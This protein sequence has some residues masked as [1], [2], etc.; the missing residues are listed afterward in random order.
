MNKGYTLI[1]TLISLLIVS[2][3]TLLLSSLLSIILKYE[4]VLHTGDDEKSIQQMRILYA[5]SKEHE[6]NGDML[7]FTY[8]YQ[9][10]NYTFHNH[11]LILEDGYQLFLSDLDTA[12]F[13]NEKNCF[14]IHYKRKD[15]VRK[16][17]IG[18]E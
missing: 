4:Y 14:Y 3:C 1:E 16:R 9:R 12:Y 2:I 18:C 17:V 10:M 6:I 13:T 15:K 8:R 5:L 7:Y 11:K